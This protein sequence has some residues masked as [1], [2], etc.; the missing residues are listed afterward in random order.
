MDRREMKKKM[1]IELIREL[2]YNEENQFGE[3]RQEVILSKMGIYDPS[4]AVKRRFEDLITEM[5]LNEQSKLS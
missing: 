3:T 2:F 1:Q 5:L 4:D